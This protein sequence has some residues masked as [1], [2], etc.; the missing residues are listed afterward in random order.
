[1][2]TRYT[3]ADLNALNSAIATGARSVSYNGQK[4]EYRDLDEMLRVRDD[5]EREL[6]TTKTKRRSR[7]V[8]N[9]GL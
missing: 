6:G 7:A 3:Q 4:V 1:M 5:M 2:S 9:R 8:F